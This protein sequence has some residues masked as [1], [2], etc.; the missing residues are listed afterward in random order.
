MCVYLGAVELTR[1]FGTR[2]GVRNGSMDIV[3]PTLDY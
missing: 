1:R 2:N 3:E